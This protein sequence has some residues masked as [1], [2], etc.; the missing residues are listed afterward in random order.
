MRLYL[1]SF[2]SHFQLLNQNQSSKYDLKLTWLLVHHVNFL[3]VQSFHW[4]HFHKFIQLV[5]WKFKFDVISIFRLLNCRLF[6]GQLWT[7]VQ[8][9]S[10]ETSSIFCQIQTRHSYWLKLIG[11]SLSR[12]IVNSSDLQ[13]R[14]PPGPFTG[15][16]QVDKAP[17]VR[18]L[19]KA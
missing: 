6:S 12:A 5:F 3:L 13:K 4:R 17:H 18:L 1:V 19:N 16:I 15:T 11:G 2:I 8:G 9:L 7:A 10:E 14:V